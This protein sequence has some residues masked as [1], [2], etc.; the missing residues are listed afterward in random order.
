MK[1]LLVVST[2][3]PP[4]PG[5]IGAHAH[6]VVQGLTALGW[7]STVITPQDYAAEEEVLKFNASRPFRVVTLPTS[8]ITAVKRAMQAA[9]V[10]RIL[11]DV[12]PDVVVA[13]GLRA[14]WLCGVLGPVRRRPWVAIGHGKE[15]GMRG[16]ERTITRHAYGRSTAVVCV[17]RYTWG[18]MYRA[19]IT[20]RMG[21]VIPN[22]GDAS[23]FTPLPE[24]ETAAFRRSLGL[25]DA[26]ILLT[27]GHV[28]ERK[29]QDIVI[30][31]LARLRGVSDVHYLMAG[32]PTKERE[33][34]AL[35]R[36]L[37]VAERVHFLGRVDTARL[38]RLL[39]ACDLFAM[40]SRHDAEGDFEG[41][42]IAV[43]EA[44]LCGRPAVVTEN[45]GLVEAI[46]VGAT[47]LCVPED[48]V[49]A[50][51][52]A[53]QNLLMDPLRRRAMGAAARARALS[54]QAWDRRV[55]EYDD[56]LRELVGARGSRA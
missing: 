26:R 18:A 10:R 20:P 27:V 43:V 46:E 25:P 15:F 3:F 6:A 40:T 8:R 23:T 9:R 13:T 14:V 37:G 12:R 51:A 16:L 32:L 1:R 30:R 11:L 41:Y 29:G 45:S 52:A 36:E 39:N 22:G 33:F 47:G 19:G 24:T 54:E 48:D 4:G 44:A 31:A 2:E 35:A 28:S 49:D 53:I 34:G 21:R 7:E 50:T 38:V 55:L 56:V 5:G 42:G 17:S